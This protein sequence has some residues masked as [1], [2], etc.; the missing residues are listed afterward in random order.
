MKITYNARVIAVAFIAFISVVPCKKASALDL[1]NHDALLTRLKKNQ[2]LSEKDIIEVKSSYPK[3]EMNGTLQLQYI[4]GQDRSGSENID[5]L[6][7]KRLKLKFNARLTEQASFVIEPEYGRGEPAIKDAYLSYKPSWIAIFAGNHRVPFSADALK[8]DINLP[9]AER[10]LASQISPDYLPGVSVVKTLLG[11]RL[12][13]QAGVWNGNINSGAEANLINSSLADSRIFSA[14]TGAGGSNV[15]IEAV[16]VA[17][18]SKGRDNFY[19][20]GNGFDNDENFNGGTSYGLGL[21]YYNSAALRDK[22]PANGLTGLNGASAYEAD[23][24]FRIWR[25][26]T[27]VEYA[28]RSLDWWQYSFAQTSNVSVTSVQTSFSAQASVLVIGGLS[29]G[30]RYETFVYDDKDAV[31]KGVYGQD[32]DK[33]LTVGLNYYFKGQN[34]KI[35][36]NYVKK[37]DV[38]PAGGKSTI[39]DTGYIQA[40]MYF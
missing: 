8:N 1:F 31:L 38:M 21:S 30:V 26:S 14:N 2:V 29:V 10:N 19:S 37:S 5:D 28:N 4:N 40:T 24:F 15:L 27:E 32:Q 3:L 18:S 39:N 6:F 34:T 20:G 17:F 35:Q 16:R 9:F 23:L 7:M 11:S 22:A 36:A 13:V 33:W 12:I 25:L